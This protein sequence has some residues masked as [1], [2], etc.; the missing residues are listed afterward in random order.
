[1]Y[2]NKQLGEYKLNSE[3]VASLELGLDVCSKT[4]FGGTF[5]Y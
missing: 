2:E 5:F 4:N 3:N 1:M